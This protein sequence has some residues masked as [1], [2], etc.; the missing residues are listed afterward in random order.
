MRLQYGL[1]HGLGTRAYPDGSTYKGEWDKGVRQ[2]Y[3]IHTMRTGSRY[4]G[5]WYRD[6]KHGVGISS[7]PYTKEALEAASGMDEGMGFS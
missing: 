3:G 2:G 1:P 7:E 4:D 5:P 6:K